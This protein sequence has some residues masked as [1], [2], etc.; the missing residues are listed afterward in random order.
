MPSVLVAAMVLIVLLV[1]LGLLLGFTKLVR[2]E[3][4]KVREASA[5]TKAATNQD[6]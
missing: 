2:A 6:A 5:T 4:Q 3:Q 1:G